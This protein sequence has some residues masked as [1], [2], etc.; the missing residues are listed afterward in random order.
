LPS[1]RL[2]DYRIDS[3]REP[4]AV[5]ADILRLGIFPSPDPSSHLLAEEPQS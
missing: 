5:V 2:A 3:A 4:A 1:Y